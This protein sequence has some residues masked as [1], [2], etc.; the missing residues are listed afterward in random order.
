[1]IFGKVAIISYLFSAVLFGVSFMMGNALGV[2][3]Y[4]PG[5]V[6]ETSLN[7]LINHH[8]INATANPTFIFGDYF[9]GLQAI[10]GI[11]FS[12][13]TGGTVGDALQAIPFLNQDP[14]IMIVFRIVYTFCGACLII[15]ILTGRD[16]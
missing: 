13:V 1:M 4:A 14:S 12:T 2:S 16:L 10:G 9:A 8:N 3:L 6:S 7:T 5:T 15:N 11:L